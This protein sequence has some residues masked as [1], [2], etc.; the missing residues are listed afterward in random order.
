MERGI[1]AHSEV[2]QIR[3]LVMLTAL[4]LGAPAWAQPADA[5][6]PAA[7]DPADPDADPADPAAEPAP[8]QVD[9]AAAAMAASQVHEQH[10]ADTS[11]NDV[12][13]FGAAMSQ[14]SGALVEVSAAYDATKDPSLLF[15]RGLLALCIGREDVGATDLQA[16]L[17]GV[18]GQSAYSDQIRD[19]RRRLRRVQVSLERGSDSTPAPGGIVAGVGLAAGTGAFAGLS[20][21]QA[22]ELRLATENL[23]EG[24]FQQADIDAAL[25]EGPQQAERANAFLGAA[26]GMGVRSL[27]AFVVTAATRGRSAGAA[28]WNAP[29]PVLA[30]A[31]T[32]GGA[33]LTVGVRW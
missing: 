1:D 26:V 7:E 18:E 8:P 30:L 22:V 13:V 17:D 25:E 5:D 27:V 3:L 23:V 15:W 20:S 4:C 29:A 11:G 28:S 14:G 19:A 6:D 21:W 10:C 31:P 24:R 32:P 12:S 33:H 9:V 2:M 16:F